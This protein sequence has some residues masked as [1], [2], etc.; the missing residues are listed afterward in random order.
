[1]IIMETNFVWWRW[2]LRAGRETSSCGGSKL[3]PSLSSCLAQGQICAGISRL[4][5]APPQLSSSH[6]F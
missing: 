6:C 4:L 2:W 3:S 5:A 1:M